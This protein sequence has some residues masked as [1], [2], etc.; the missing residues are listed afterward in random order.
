M[1]RYVFAAL[2]ASS[3]SPASSARLANGSFEQSVPMTVSQKVTLSAGST[4]LPGWMISSGN[5]DLVSTYWKASDGRRSIDLN[6]TRRG[7]VSTTVYGTVIGRSYDVRFD[8]AANPVGQ[9]NAKVVR[10]S[11]GLESATFAS[12]SAGGSL[13]AMNWATRLFT[14]TST[15]VD[16]LLTFRAINGAESGAAIDNVR[17]ALQPVPL[18]ASAP[19]AALGLAA[20]ALLRRRN[21]STEA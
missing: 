1:R 8:M 15:A 19:L 21:T 9:P 20:L 7:T 10:V 3:V 18:P 16:Q 4:A 2:L 5:I 12:N 14:F 13:S 17:V 6:G 11:A